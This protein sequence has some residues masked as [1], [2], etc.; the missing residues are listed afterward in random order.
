MPPQSSGLFSERRELMGMGGVGKK[1]VD[2]VKDN[3]LNLPMICFMGFTLIDFGLLLRSMTQREP[4]PAEMK[5]YAIHNIVKERDE[6]AGQQIKTCFNIPLL[7]GSQRWSG[8]GNPSSGF[9]FA[10]SPMLTQ[11][12]IA[13]CYHGDGSF[14]DRSKL[15]PL[16]LKQKLLDLKCFLCEDYGDLRAWGVVNRNN[17]YASVPDFVRLL[18]KF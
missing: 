3:V 12:L 10:V 11:L 16:Q 14:F 15:F 6:T 5:I 8:F 2:D 4:S 17:N 1:K 13:K 7:N 18:N 9:S